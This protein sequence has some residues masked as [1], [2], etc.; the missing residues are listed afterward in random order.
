MSESVALA[1]LGIVYFILNASQYYRWWG[2]LGKFQRVVFA[3]PAVS[4]LILL[5]IRMLK[6]EKSSAP[7]FYWIFFMLAVPFSV[8]SVAFIS[9][10]FS[11][12]RHQSK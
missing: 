8:G 1:S 5:V 10:F 12:K 9:R 6:P 3:V 2:K 4:L 7:T 11:R